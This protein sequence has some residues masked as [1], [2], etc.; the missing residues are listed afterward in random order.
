VI[1]RRIAIIGVGLIG[2]SIGEAVRKRGLAET[3]IGIGRREVSIK[4]A[5]KRGAIDEGILDFRKGV[6]GADLVIIATPVCF[7]PKAAEKISGSLKAGCIVTDVGSTKVEVV[8]ALERIMPKE[9]SFVGSHPLAGSQKR[10]VKFAQGDLF[11][12]SVVIMA[13]TKKTK[14]QALDKLSGF[15]KSLGVGKVVVKSSK[16]HDRIVAEI[17]HM[18]H[19][20]A[21]AIVNTPSDKSLEFSSSGFRDTTRI[22]ASDPGIWR[23]ICVTNSR[24]I[25]K[26]L[27]RYERNI[28][29]LKKLIKNK[30]GARLRKEF[31]RSK[32]RREKLG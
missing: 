15:W 10:G 5:L 1:F 20:A 22:A 24:Q 14:K 16:E 28:A 26:A 17:S 32:A 30:S 7:I 18:P 8:K 3:V 2:G 25:V 19:I 27:E 13:K 21:V 6:R 12:D 23:D 9:V 29:K 4:E 31:E 11:E